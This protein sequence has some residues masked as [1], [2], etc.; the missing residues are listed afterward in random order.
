MKKTNI[1]GWMIVGM[2]VA[3]NPVLADSEDTEQIL[4]RCN[5][6]DS[7]AEA[8]DDADPGDTILVLGTCHESVTITTDRLTIEGQGNAELVGVDGTQDVITIKG[9]HA[10]TL[11]GFSIRNGNIGILGKE[12]SSF[13]L[14][15]L[16]VRDNSNTGIRLEGNSSATITDT[17]AEHNGLLGIDIDRASEARFSGNFVSQDNGVF[18]MILS[19]NSSST[20][21]KANVTVRR[22]ALGIQVGINSSFM[23]AD[24]ETVVT[25]ANNL[26][27]GLT[28]VSGSTL[29]VFE[30]AIVAEGNQFNHGV[31]ANSNSNID[32]D[33]GGSITARN[34]GVDGIQLEDSLLNLFNMPGLPAS[35]V[36]VENNG[37][38]GL[39]AFQESRIDLSGDS[40]ITSHSNLEAGVF[41]DNG[42]SA[43]II[44]ST[45]RDNLTD[46]VLSF[47]SRADL[48]NNLIETITCDDTV[49]VR[50]DSGITCPK[51]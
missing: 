9:A 34:N 20:F 39:S 43:R 5:H 2:L 49:L 35:S 16:V 10:V 4:V 17:T 38:H 18:G 11:T 25:A 15:N 6:G 26:A 29:F 28:V 13:M 14:N 21:A 31:S 33:R 42:S 44:N 51:P 32:L 50:G 1:N 37:R 12:A 19:S 23:I 41:V 36:L 3:T 30:G 40:E 46:L 48:V 47:G 24:A 22:N 8:I 45:I 7:L 27:T